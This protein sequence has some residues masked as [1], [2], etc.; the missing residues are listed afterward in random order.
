[1]FLLTSA[2]LRFLMLRVVRGQEIAL[3]WEVFSIR[4]QKLVILL[5][6]DYIS[7]LFLRTVLIISGRVFLYR[8]SYISG[9]KVRSRFALLILSFVIRIRLLI[10]S[11]NLVRLLLGWDGLGVTSYLLVCYYNSEK[12][13][14]AR[15]VTALTNRIGDVLILLIIAVMCRLGL[16]NYGLVRCSNLSE[17][18]YIFVLI[19]VAAMTKRA[20]IPFSAWL[21][22]AMAAPT[23]V[24]ALVHSSTLVTAGVYLLFRYNYIIVMRGW[25]STILWVGL[26][27]I[28]IAGASAI[29]ELDIKKVIA[30]STLSQ[31]GVIFFRLGLGQPFLTFFHL[32]SHAYFKAIL[33][34]AAGA[35]IH[36][37]KDYQDLRKVGSRSLN[38]PLLG[39]VILIA[40]ISLCGMP[41]LSGF[42]SKDLILEIMM[43]NSQGLFLFIISI[44][45]TI[46]TI[47]YSCR[48]TLS[49]FRFYSRR[50]AFSL[51]SDSDIIII[52][53]IGILVLP[54]IAGG[55]ALR[56]LI[57]RTPLIF[58]RLW[59]KLAIIN[60][61]LASAF[62]VLFLLNFKFSPAKKAT[63]LLHEIWFLP[64]LFSPMSTNVGLNN[65]KSFLKVGDLTWIP[66]VTWVRFVR[67]NSGLRY[68]SS[69]LR[70][71]ALIRILIIF[72]LLVI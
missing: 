48:L 33:F 41:F 47:L 42:Y 55:F 71:G 65:S 29:F 72:R 49:L 60:L 15:I 26:L 50:E 21:P 36:S 40:N 53:S 1:M 10:L 16:F 6:F 19:F 43:I 68:L 24:S 25:A 22:A 58:L 70:S 23:P 28:T 5:I 62:V 39:S 17:I 57:R 56:G 66:Y 20:Q 7:L 35:I 14:N 18:G 46:L 67:F 38:K 13:F 27:T 34:I 3:E 51:E 44:L 2:I 45:A 63:R 52:I 9:D 59:Q 4:G 11:P 31:L 37:V 12:R 8:S 54:S 30:L 32:I 64:Y 61:I 69:S